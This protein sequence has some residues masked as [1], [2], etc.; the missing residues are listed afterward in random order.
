MKGRE[1]IS[2][3]DV[4][5]YLQEQGIMIREPD[6]INE[7][8][9]LIFTILGYQSML[10]LPAFDICSPYELAIS[11][12]H[13]SNGELFSDPSKISVQMAERPL[14][15]FLREFGDVLPRR[16]NNQS[17][18][19][20]EN[21]ND[22]VTLCPPEFNAHLL[23]ILLRISFRWVD[24]LGL[25]LHYDKASRTLS[26]FKYPSFCQAMLDCRGAIYS[27]ASPEK[28]SPH[29]RK[30]DIRQFLKEVLLSYRLLF[31]QTSSS[32]N[33]YDV[34][35]PESKNLLEL[36]NLLDSLCASETIGRNAYNTPEDQFVYIPTYDFPMLHERIVPIA[37][38]LQARRPNSM[39]DLFRDKR[40]RLQYWTFCL[41]AIIGGVSIILS[42]VQVLLQAVEIHRG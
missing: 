34:I 5:R 8:R 32:R 14:Y 26:I 1:G 10:Y 13:R 11:N 36:D 24:T 31:G 30:E 23:G 4:V 15:L 3:D 18:Q 39:I 7:Q 6:A 9:L 2:I 20:N 28:E 35:K 22:T 38:E 19:G 29:P 16:M 37:K 12:N 40:D 33:F 41:V 17:V 21:Y 42:F 27:F 25:H